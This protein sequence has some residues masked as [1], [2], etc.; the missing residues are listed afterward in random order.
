MGNVVEIYP[1]VLGNE[2]SNDW[3]QIVTLFE[4]AVCK[5]DNFGQIIIELKCTTAAMDY[6]FNIENIGYLRYKIR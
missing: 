6:F 2:K 4:E 1:S 3:L 5:E